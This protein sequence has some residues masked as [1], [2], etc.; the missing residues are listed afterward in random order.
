MHCCPAVNGLSPSLSYKIEIT[1]PPWREGASQPSYL[2]I[3]QGVTAGTCLCMSLTGQVF[4]SSSTV[5]REPRRG[6]LR[7]RL[8]NRNGSKTSAFVSF[9]TEPWGWNSKGMQQKDHPPKQ[10]KIK[11]IP[12]F[13]CLKIKLGK[14]QTGADVMKMHRTQKVEK[15]FSK[16][17]E[18]LAKERQ[19]R[20]ADLQ[21]KHYQYWYISEFCQTR[22]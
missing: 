11:I 12:F 14:F 15:K 5:V 6:R 8:P 18:A 16:L 19:H 1:P 10:E 9:E 13:L 3:F 4:Q 21:V 17:K 22:W 2:V 7:L 20:L